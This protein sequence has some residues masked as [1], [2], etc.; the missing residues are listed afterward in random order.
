[1]ANI[2]GIY[3]KDMVLTQYAFIAYV[4]LTPDVVGIST[5]PEEEEAFNHFW[6][7]I[8]HMLN[9]PDR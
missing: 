5:K 6:R 3:H 4:L 2:G 7:V 1:M 9:I 8:G